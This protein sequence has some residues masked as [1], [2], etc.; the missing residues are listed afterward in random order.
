MSGFITPPPIGTILRKIWG[1][2][3]APEKY[4]V[5]AIVDF[6]EDGET[7]T[8]YQMVLRHYSRRKG[9]LYTIEER[10]SLEVGLFKIVRTPRKRPAKSISGIPESI[11]MVNRSIERLRAVGK[12]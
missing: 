7:F 6:V 12:K 9:W 5:R 10:A 2:G 8:T 11:A 1:G 3:L 4:Y